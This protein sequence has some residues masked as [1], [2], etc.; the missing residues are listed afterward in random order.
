MLSYYQDAKR[1]D[2]AW[3]I[4]SQFVA[5]VSLLSIIVIGVMHRAWPNFLLAPV[6]VY[7]QI[8]LT[9]RWWA[10]GTDS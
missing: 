4:L 7:V 6:L 10:Q 2:L 5:V 3:G 8:Q 9:R 1:H